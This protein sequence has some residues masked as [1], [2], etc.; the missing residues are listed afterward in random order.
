M[1]KVL[2]L[3]DLFSKAYSPQFGAQGLSAPSQ[4]QLGRGAL[5][6]MIASLSGAGDLLGGIS[7][8]LNKSYGAYGAGVSYFQKQEDE[9]LK[10]EL[11]MQSRRADVIGKRQAYEI[12]EKQE[13][14]AQ[15]GFGLKKKYDAAAEERAQDDQNIERATEHRLATAQEAAMQDRAEM[16]KKKVVA[17]ASGKKAAELFGRNPQ[18]VALYS[19]MAAAGQY[20]ELFSAIKE[21]LRPVSP[22]MIRDN[23]SNPYSKPG[24]G[25]VQRNEKD[26]SIRV[27]AHNKEDDGVKFRPNPQQIN[28]LKLDILEKEMIPKYLKDQRANEPGIIDSVVSFFGGGDQEQVQEPMSVY[29]GMDIPS[30]LMEEAEAEAVKRY[31]G[32]YQKSMTAF[33]GKKITPDVSSLQSGPVA[34]DPI[35]DF[36]SQIAL[37][38]AIRDALGDDPTLDEETKEAQVDEIRKQ[39]MGRVNSGQGSI[40]DAITMLEMQG[41][42]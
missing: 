16:R 13:L 42:Y 23:W 14:R 39:I 19:A 29:G 26:G 2:D 10:N 21:S 9:R 12:N 35:Q 37:D 28:K 33:N 41:G 27:L 25:F 5:Q 6:Q 24:I 4:R 40:E 38:K 18:E 11:E 22:Y 3:A 8:G 7:E 31:V 36:S 30:R 20:S 1:P 34:G 32:A 15:E 17:E